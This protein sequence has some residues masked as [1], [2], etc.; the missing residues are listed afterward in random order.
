MK[1]LHL[2]TTP[3]HQLAFPCLRLG[4][5]WQGHRVEMM[6]WTAFFLFVSKSI[7]RSAR[8]L[9]PAGGTHNSFS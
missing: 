7:A 4:L 6:N 1:S 9:R 3:V 5:L 8:Q 2:P